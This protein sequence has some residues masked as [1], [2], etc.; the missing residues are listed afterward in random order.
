MV[1]RLRWCGCGAN[2]HVGRSRSLPLS[3]SWELLAPLSVC[4][5]RCHKSS[6][7]KELE[8]ELSLAD[9]ISIAQGM[10]SLPAHQL[11]M[12]CRSSLPSRCESE[13]DFC[14]LTLAL[15]CS[16]QRVH[17]NAESSGPARMICSRLPARDESQLHLN[18]TQ[19][20]AHSHHFCSAQPILAT[21]HVSRCR[22]NFNSVSGGRAIS[23]HLP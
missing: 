19:L 13:A 11:L 10:D 8:C 15:L 7:G 12:Q 5:R 6:Q 1:K 18:S 23:Q 3:A 22:C 16:E 21:R 4:A 17:L 20:T 2:W 9:S 14:R